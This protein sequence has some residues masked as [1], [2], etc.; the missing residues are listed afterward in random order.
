MKYLTKGWYDMFRR[1]A[2]T[3]WIIADPKAESFDEVHYLR[4]VSEFLLQKG[5]RGLA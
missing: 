5:H 4:R 2:I 1:S 3:K